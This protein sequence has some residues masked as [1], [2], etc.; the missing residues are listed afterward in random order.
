MQ[1]KDSNFPLMVLYLHT[2]LLL[3]S[4]LVVVE[5]VSLSPKPDGSHLALGRGFTI[6]ELFTSRPEGPS[7]DGDRRLNL[8]H[9]SPRGLLHPSLKDL[10][11]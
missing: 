11:D 6:L 3:P 8:H 2:S 7:T 5:L 4:T 9:G 10:V 1:E